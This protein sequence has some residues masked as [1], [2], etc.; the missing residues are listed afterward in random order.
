MI[1]S[2]CV[3]VKK[4]IEKIPSIAN[5]NS[6]VLIIGE[7]GTGKEVLAKLIHTMGNR[8]KKEMV[9]VNCAAIP[10]TLLESE[11]FGYKK[12]S[13]TGSAS[14]HTGLFEL[15]DNST[16]FLDEIG[17]MPLSIQAKMLRVLQERKIRPIGSKSEKTVNFRLISA[18]HRNLK[19]EVSNGHFREDLYYRLSVIP[20]YIPPLRQRRE[21]IPNL[22][23]RFST[24][25][26]LKHNMQVPKFSDEAIKNLMDRSWPG[27]IRELENTVENVIVMH[28]DKE[29]FQ[30]ED[31]P[32]EDSDLTQVD[33]FK[34]DFKKYK[35]FPTLTELTDE[36]I[37]F[38]LNECN[39]HQGEAS[40]ILGLSRRT[41]YRKLK[42]SPSDSCASQ[43]SH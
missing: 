9:S 4:I 43:L 27:N 25:F 39:L 3:P 8:S 37:H 24:N 40:R 11:L 35:K 10:E 38:I 16:I 7:S 6:N 1:S 34:W 28:R 20:L 36:Y 26:A 30:I 23:K 12:G 31:L 41:I 14:D 32:H 22:I 13:F 18:T 5:S 19:E 21:D 33:H 2:Q 15:A 42:S 29:I 17:D